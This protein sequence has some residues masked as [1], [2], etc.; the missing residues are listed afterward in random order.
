M[1]CIIRLDFPM[2]VPPLMIMDEPRVI[3]RLPMRLSGSFL[4]SKSRRSLTVTMVDWSSSV[5]RLVSQSS[6]DAAPRL[7]SNN[8]C[9]EVGLRHAPGRRE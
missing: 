8:R 7:V 6:Q 9:C 5:S 1:I 4:G 3:Q 2:P